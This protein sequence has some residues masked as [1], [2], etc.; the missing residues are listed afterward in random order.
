M[1][2]PEGASRL[3]PERSF[4]FGATRYQ[5]LDGDWRQAYA[6]FRRFTASKGHVT[7][8]NFNPPV[9]WNELYDNKLWWIADA[10]GLTPENLKKYYQKKDMEVEADKAKEIGCGC[11]YLD[12]GWDTSFGSN[13]WG[14]DRL[15]PQDEFVRWLKDKYGMTLALHTPLAPWSEPTELSGRGSPH[16][17]GRQ[18]GRRDVY[19]KS[20]L[21]EQQS[22]AAQGT[23]Q[24]RRLL[25]DVRRFVV[26]R[27]VLGQDRTATRCR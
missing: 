12:P 25:P 10:G 1:G 24:E 15:G 9:H 17:Q 8:P 23:L 5:V 3:A 22:L 26:P 20:R 11:L 6:A 14:A 27:R 7:P 19:R 4:T 2:D 13:I 18:S 16:G 21:Y